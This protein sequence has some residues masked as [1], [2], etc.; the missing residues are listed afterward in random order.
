[1]KINTEKI[2]HLSK[3]KVV[4]GNWNLMYLK[5]KLFCLFIFALTLSNAQYMEGYAT[6]NYAGVSGINYNPASTVDTRIKLDINFF[7]LSTT[8]DNNFLGLTTNFPNPMDTFLLEKSVLNN[9]GTNKDIYLNADILGPSFLFTIDETKSIGFTSQFRTLSNFTNISEG[10]ANLFYTNLED[11]RLTGLP[12]TTENSNISNVMWSEF[13]VV[14]GQEIFKKNHS[15]LSFGI[16]PKITQGIQAAGINIKNLYTELNNDSTVLVNGQD[17]EYF[18]SQNL[19]ETWKSNIAKFNGLGFGVDLGFNYEWRSQPDSCVY[20]MDGKLNSSREVSKH[21]LRIGLTVSDIGYIK[22]KSG[23]SGKLNALS[24]SWNPNSF[25]L[26][27]LSGYEDAINSE[28][29]SSNEKKNMII[30]L[31][32]SFST[33]MDYNIYKGIYINATYFNSIKKNGVVQINYNSRFTITPRWDWKWMGAYLPYSITSEGNKHLGLNIMFGPFLIGTRDIG[34]FL[35]K[36]E[37]YF[38]NIHL[39]VKVTSLHYR[40]EDFDKD[41]VSDKIDKCPELKGIWSFK[42][43][44][45]QDGDSIPDASDKCP[46]TAGLKKFKGCP[47]T[48]LDGIA[49]LQDECPKLPGIKKLKGCPDKDGD[50]IRDEMDKCPDQIGLALFEGCPDTDGDSVAD[51]LDACPDLIG[52]LINLGCPDSDLDGIFNFEDSCIYTKGYD[53]NNGCPYKDKDGDGIND[54]ID[55]CPS[56]FGSKSNNGCPLIDQDLDG[57]PDDEDD[58][59]KTK[60]DPLNSGCPFI[61]DEDEEVIEF[62]FKNLNFETGK[63]TILEKS[64]PS[65]NALAEM[66]IEKKTWILL[67]RGHTDNIGDAQNNLLL[68]K[69]RVEVTKKYLVN[70]GVSKDSLILK[71]FGETKPIVKNNNALNRAIN[72]R[73]EM[74]IIFD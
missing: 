55:Q 9:D 48:D 26:R 29:S 2:K 69:N 73:V 31:P 19:S 12:I 60:G 13:G 50:G 53:D 39:G 30:G 28:F 66:L 6:S 59:P 49:D 25:N 11:N 61:N 8:I 67:L 46:E 21:K 64:F 63:S 71:Y 27:T 18:T 37:N 56:L 41:G 10:F 32:T 16:K 43:C 58:C 7:T 54:Q 5:L 70:K 42:G 34:T 4:F 36:E 20:K 35:W 23:S 45:D 40:P 65:L 22:F 57:V 52:E 1:M 44:P 47:D 24:D 68:S 38:G 62:A 15:W 72:R 17:V 3:L 74:E 14:Y 51:Y 33:Q